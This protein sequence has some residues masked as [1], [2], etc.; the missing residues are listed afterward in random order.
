MQ[1]LGYAYLN[2]SVIKPDLDPVSH[3]IT[4]RLV[5]AIT[6]GFHAVKAAIANLVKSLRSE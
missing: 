5:E 4:N 1:E 6:V 2:G 3:I